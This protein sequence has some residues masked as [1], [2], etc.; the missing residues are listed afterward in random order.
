V[1]LVI[2]DEHDAAVSAKARAAAAKL[3]E[4]LFP[5][6]LASD[7]LTPVRSLRIMAQT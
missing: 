5:G 4:Q 7:V 6:K 2:K 3:T 1:E